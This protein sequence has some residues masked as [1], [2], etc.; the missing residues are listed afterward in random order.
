MSNRILKPL[1]FAVG[2]AFIGSFA[3]S[4]DAV[5]SSFALTD[6]DSGYMLVGDEAAAEG[7]AKAAEGKCGEGKCGEDKAA[8]EGKCGEGKCGEGKAAHD[9]DAEGKCGEGKCGEEKPAEGDGG[10]TRA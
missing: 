1:T 9:K 5:A 4:Q 6:L 2:A 3:L 7:D 10:A 8:A